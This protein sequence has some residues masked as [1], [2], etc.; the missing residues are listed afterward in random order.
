VTDGPDA[1]DRRWIAPDRHQSVP[2]E[3]TQ[4][5]AQVAGVE[6]ESMSK[7]RNTR[8]VEADLEQQA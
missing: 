7:V 2:L 6:L 3:L 5:P 4:E 8:S 1:G